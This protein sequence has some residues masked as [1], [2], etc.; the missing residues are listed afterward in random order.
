VEK[1]YKASA[2]ICRFEGVFV[3]RTMRV[4]SFLRFLRELEKCDGLAFEARKHVED[5]IRI[6][7]LV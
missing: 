4:D 5:S 6:A 2:E 1:L 7:E 3:M